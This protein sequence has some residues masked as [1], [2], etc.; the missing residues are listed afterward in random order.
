LPG[1]AGEA[2]HRVDAALAPPREPQPGDPL[3]HLAHPALVGEEVVVVELE[4]VGAVLPVEP[5]RDAHDVLGGVGD[6]PAVEHVHDRAEVAEVRAARA[7]VVVE[8]AS[9]EE[10]LRR[11][12]LHV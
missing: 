9:S 11:V 6:P 5:A 1:R 2:E 12:A 4:R 8:G 7:R 10:G 3:G